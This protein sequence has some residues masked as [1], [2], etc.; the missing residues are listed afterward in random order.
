MT[1]RHQPNVKPHAGELREAQS[2]PCAQLRKGF[3]LI[4]DCMS[5]HD[6]NVGQDA[7]DRN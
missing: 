1:P 2:Q 6:P 3:Q 4:T 7:A 5:V